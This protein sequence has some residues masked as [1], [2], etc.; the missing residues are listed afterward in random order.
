MTNRRRMGVSRSLRHGGFLFL[1]ALPLGISGRPPQEPAE[2][3]DVGILIG[4]S[5]VHGFGHSPV[6]YNERGS[7]FLEDRYR[8][9]P[10]LDGPVEPL[11]G[12]L[13]A[14]LWLNRGVTGNPSTSVRARWSRDV[15]EKL[16]RG[17]QK[18]TQRVRCLLISV[19]LTDIGA[20][21]GSDNMKEAE[22][23]L[24]DNLMSFVK[25][26]KKDGIRIAFF[27]PPDPYRAPMGKTFRTLDGR[28]IESF[29]ES[30]KY[31]EAGCSEFNG[32]VERTRAFM[33]GPLQKAGAEVIDYANVL[34]TEYFL[35]ATHP[36]SDGYEELGRILRSL[37]P[38]TPTPPQKGR[39][40]VVSSNPNAPDSPS[41][42]PRRRSSQRPGN[43][44][45][46]G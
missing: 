16:D 10:N 27:E 32:A 20:A 34:S 46:R 18:S 33:E 4:D 8:F 25:R 45:R 2:S 35:D 17:H 26:A 39:G 23:T 30:R 29:C 7:V 38:G 11:A 24:R 12:F 42:I 21:V 1:A 28:T 22:A 14:P 9:R 40:R 15:A 5:I 19:G 6:L 41:S 44:G 31:D 43:S 36:T 13:G 37:Y 3:P